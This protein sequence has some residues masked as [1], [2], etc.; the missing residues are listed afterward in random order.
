MKG[1]DRTTIKWIAMITMLID[2][3]GYA[4]FPET[5]RI[6]IVIGII[7]N[8]IGRSAFPL[9][10]FLLADGFLRT[11]S[12]PRF[13]LRLFICAVISEVPF[14]L[15]QSK[16]L[17]NI[18][19]QNVLWTLLIF[20]SYM[21]ISDLLLK[22]A[23][24]YEVGFQNKWIIAMHVFAGIGALCIAT[25]LR[26]DYLGVGVV[27]GIAM[28]HGLS[29]QRVHPDF[30]GIPLSLIGYAV[31]LILMTSVFESTIYALPTML[32]IWQYH[33]RCEHKMPKWI[34]YAFYPAHLSVIALVLFLTGQL[35]LLP[36]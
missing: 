10:L 21:W 8:V 22:Q 25:I 7:C 11:R 30:K 29:L 24:E 35:Q 1:I 12:K 16:T 20:F 4:F 3:A 32:L 14:D 33:G 31:G 2:H 26:T 27:G 36:Q 19:S 9:F 6:F 28:Y 34:G 17:F 13:F 5:N 18:G 15:V 23:K